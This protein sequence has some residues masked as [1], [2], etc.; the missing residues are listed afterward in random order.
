VPLDSSLLEAVRAA[1]GRQGPALDESLLADFLSQLDAAYF[2]REAPE[3]VARHARLSAELGPSRR[4]R[5]LV[6]PRGEDRY[7]VAVVAFDYFAELSILCGL[8]SSHGLDIEAGHVHTLAPAPA[9]ARGPAGPRRI[10]DVFRVRPRQGGAPEAEGLERELVELLDLVA[11]GRGLEA[12]ARINLRLVEALEAAPVAP[13]AAAGTVEIR[14]DD[15]QD[16][17][18]TTMDVRGKDSPGFLYALAN[19]LAMR[20]IYVHEVRIESVDG[21]ARDRFRISHADGRRLLDEAEQEALRRA[22]ALIRQFTYLLPG[23]PDPVRALRYFDQLLDRTAG[24]PAGLELFPTPEKLRDLARFL[25]SSAFLWEDVLRER[26]DRFLPLVAEWRARPLRGRS[27]LERALRVRLRAEPRAA[28]PGLVRAFRDEE[29][30]LVE[31]RRLLDPSLDLERFSSALADLAEAL[32]SESAR[33]ALD[34]LVETHGPPLAEDGRECGYAVFALGKFGG[35]EIGYASDLEL[36][37]AFGPEGRTERTG[38]EAGRFFDDLVREAV[39]ILAAPEE[40][41]FH[42]DLRLRPHGGKGPLASPLEA[43][44]DYYR[45]GGL[46]APFERQALI[47][48]RFV[49]GDPDLGREVERVRDAFVWSEEP[50]NREDA[51][52]LRQ[53][54]ARELVPAGRFN[55]KLSRGGLVDAEYTVQYLQVRHGRDHPG[56]RAPATLVAL[57]RL[58]EAKILD[59]GEHRDLRAGYLFW[60]AVADALRVVRG[61]S[62]D[63]LLPEKGSDEMGFLARRLG[64]A[65]GRAQAAAALDAHVNHHRRRLRE[66]YDAR[67]GKAE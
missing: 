58:L 16:P 38:L 53:R 55:V 7:D 52:H 33:A 40:G 29:T 59:P 57:D 13:A 10:V 32:V 12:R 11:E 49:A 6:T 61:Q 19:A 37:F 27:E 24:S 67:F 8:L 15:E 1:L 54:Q 51:A 17:R 34:R 66:I 25:G 4:A 60:R 65:G 14:F 18:F 26:I 5:L 46:A 62:R 63:L 23:A 20:G 45:R 9:P 39:D 56:L 41:L 28:W 3:D 48:L 22:V 47:K 50:W 2:E 44:R 35:R 21:E 36:L 31:A 42:V 64:Y 30:L 43:L